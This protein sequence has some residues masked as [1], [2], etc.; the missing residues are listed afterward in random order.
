MGDPRIWASEL[1]TLL[2]PDGTPDLFAMVKAAR[3]AQTQTDRVL[4]GGPCGEFPEL[5]LYCQQRIVRSIRAACP[6]L[7]L[8]FGA[9]DCATDKAARLVRLHAEW[10]VHAHLCTPCSHL[11]VN[12]PSEPVRHFEALKAAD[13]E[14]LFLIDGISSAGEWLAPVC[15]DGRTLLLLRPALLPLQGRLPASRCIGDEVTAL[16]RPDS[17]IPFLSS[18][19]WMFPPLARRFP[20]IP[21]AARS[22]ML[23]LLTAAR[24]P[25]A[26]SKY[27]ARR[28]GLSVS[29][30]LSPVSDPPSGE[31]EAL[32]ERALDT[33]CGEVKQLA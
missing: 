4:L 9:A 26:A 21:E 25:A 6:K 31:E 13:P 15:A 11:S 5:S 32:L 18:L 8:L 23:T 2:L 19:A 12:D 24:H 3:L 27:A 7:T 16:L 17:G 10:G 14:G 22:S 33:L 29:A 20:A 28:A 1:P 30:A